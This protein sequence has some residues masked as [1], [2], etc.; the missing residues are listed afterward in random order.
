MKE[1]NFNNDRTQGQLWSHLVNYS[2]QH[3]VG[4]N[5]ESKTLLQIIPTRKL[6]I[7]QSTFLLME[8]KEQE[9]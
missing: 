2:L 3:L 1:L 4:I 5:A 8:M 9:R 7:D 6:S